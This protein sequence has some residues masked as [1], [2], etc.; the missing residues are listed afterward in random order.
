M[1]EICY[2]SD[3]EVKQSRVRETNTQQL[4]KSH[5]QR[6]KK[7]VMLLE[8]GSWGQQGL[9]PQLTSIMGARTMKMQPL[10]EKPPDSEREKSKNSGNSCPL[11]L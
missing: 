9:E 5:P 4:K 2:S 8:T 6:D 3:G 7:E 10:K 1:Q 11:G